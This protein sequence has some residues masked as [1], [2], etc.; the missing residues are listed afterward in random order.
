M[1]VEYLQPWAINDGNNVPDNIY[2]LQL[3]KTVRGVTVAALDL[4]YW[5]IV[6]QSLSSHLCNTR[7]V[8]VAPCREALQEVERYFLMQS[9]FNVFTLHNELQH[10]DSS[11]HLKFTS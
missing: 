9:E 5:T 1:D 7:G 3:V 4:F 11:Y 8:C 2:H 10:S 6:V